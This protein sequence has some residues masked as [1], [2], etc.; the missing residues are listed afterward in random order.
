[1]RECARHFQ[2]TRQVARALQLYTTARDWDA[3]LR[4]CLHALQEQEEERAAD[5]GSSSK[6]R[7]DASAS[8]SLLDAAREIAQ[9]LLAAAADDATAGQQETAA[10]AVS[11]E[12]V[13]RLADLLERRGHP[14]DAVRLHLYRL[15]H[16]HQPQHQQQQQ[17]QDPSPSPSS[18]ADAL[19]LARRILR[20]CL[21]HEVTLT[22]GMIDQLLTATA[23][24]ATIN[25]DE[26]R[27]QEEGKGKDDDGRAALL[28]HEAADVCAAQG[29]HASASRLFTQAG[30]RRK[31][32]QSLFALGDAD[33]II[34]YTAAARRPELFLLAA[35]HLRETGAWRRDERVRAAVREFYGRGKTEESV[36]RAFEE[37]S[38]RCRML[39]KHV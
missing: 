31:G 25:N 16:L 27:Q 5:K 6:P 28:L 33:G 20:L 35:Q 18:G 22:E 10:A 32:L 9:G 19:A 17:P 21:Q 30:D 36:V 34:H 39:M 38:G 12:R 8:S 2:R 1:M 23:N 13:E 24:A 37:E 3:A 15:S 4:L 11:M 7:A 29:A 14:R 26:K